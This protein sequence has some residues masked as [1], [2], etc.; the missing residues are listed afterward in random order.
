MRGDLADVRCWFTDC[1]EPVRIVI[2]LHRRDEPLLTTPDLAV[3]AD[4]LRAAID[5]VAEQLL[6]GSE[7]TGVS[8]IRA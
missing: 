3:C 8:V 1:Y 6:D 2:K 7:C 5:V 4:H